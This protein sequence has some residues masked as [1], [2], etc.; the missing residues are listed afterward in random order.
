[1]F[2]KSSRPQRSQTMDSS[3]TISA[4]PALPAPSLLS[5]EAAPL[6]EKSKDGS[7]GDASR[8]WQALSTSC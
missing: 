8:L 4:S 6:R 7:W 5:A 1:M 3:F 2:L